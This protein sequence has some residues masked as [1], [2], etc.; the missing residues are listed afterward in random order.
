MLL[1][2]THTSIAYPV[3]IL[4]QVMNHN[5]MMVYLVYLS[6]ISWMVAPPSLAPLTLRWPSLFTVLENSSSQCPLAPN[7]TT[8]ICQTI[9]IVTSLWTK[10]WNGI[11]HQTPPQLDCW[12]S[13]PKTKWHGQLVASHMF[14]TNKHD[15]P[16]I[17]PTSYVIHACSRWSAYSTT[18][19]QR[20][21][22]IFILPNKPIIN[23][24]CS[25]FRKENDVW[26]PKHSRWKHTIRKHDL[27]KQTQ[28]WCYLG[29]PWK[30][31]FLPFAIP[32]NM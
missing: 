19:H 22:Q 4:H 13:P 2:L 25:T 1:A 27:S 26:K 32:L 10:P 16:S 6:W 9:C 5:A 15:V 14:Q 3:D 30:P 12:I 8:C 21:S 17:H 24:V 11:T 31:C 28:P 29:L 7:I 20:W 23:H 18:L